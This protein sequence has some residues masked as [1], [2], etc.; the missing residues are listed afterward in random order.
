MAHLEIVVDN[1]AKKL[2]VWIYTS[3]INGMPK[4]VRF[5]ALTKE[6]V[7]NYLVTPNIQLEAAVAGFRNG[8]ELSLLS[9]GDIRAKVPAC[10]EHVLVPIIWKEDE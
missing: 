3:E 4:E 6:E 7:I 10:K 1:T 9:E 5:R 2:A 8:W